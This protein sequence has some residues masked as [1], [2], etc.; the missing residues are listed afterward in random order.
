[1]FFFLTKVPLSFG[2]VGG[3]KITKRQFFFL[4]RHNFNTSDYPI[5]SGV[6]RLY[7]ET[8]PLYFHVS[9]RMPLLMHERHQY[10]ASIL[11]FYTNRG[12]V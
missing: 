6:R 1:M 7:L 12:L 11:R 4:V 8:I 5:E 10:C 9:R 2:H 3:N